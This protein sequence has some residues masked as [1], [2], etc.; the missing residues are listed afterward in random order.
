[1]S[2]GDKVLIIYNPSAG[3]A[4]KGFSLSFIKAYMKKNKID[5][6]FYFIKREISLR[7]QIKEMIA[8]GFNIFL[9]AGGDGTV[10][11]VADALYG[12][13]LPLAIIP[14]GT[15]NLIAL[16]LAIPIDL[17]KAL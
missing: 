3:L 14:L 17:K 5:H 1:M 11:L 15:G 6:D 13:N 16:E 7:N 8:L 9:A 10:S 4:L 12:F 2:P